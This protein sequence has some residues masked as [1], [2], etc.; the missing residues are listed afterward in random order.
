MFFM[1]LILLV[2]LY[3]L[4][5]SSRTPH[6][7]AIGSGGPRLIFYTLT[8]FIVPPFHIMWVIEHFTPGLIQGIPI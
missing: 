4:L 5:L 1:A 6:Y 2:V 8:L 3:L 7:S